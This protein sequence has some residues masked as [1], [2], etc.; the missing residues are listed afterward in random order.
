MTLPTT[1]TF[2]AEIKK[3]ALANNDVIYHLAK[4]NGKEKPLHLLSIIRWFKTNDQRLN[5]NY[6]LDIIAKYLKLNVED[7]LNIPLSQFELS[8][9]EETL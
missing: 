3:K 6:N 5:V 1:N 2:K 7:L 9:K 4:A 8:L